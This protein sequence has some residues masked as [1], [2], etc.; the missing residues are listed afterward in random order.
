MRRLSLLLSCAALLVA[1]TGC[2][3]FSQRHPPPTTPATPPPAAAPATSPPL[4]ANLLALAEVKTFIQ[5][6]ALRH[7]FNPDELNRLLGAANVQRKILDAMAAPA[8]AKPWH[9]YRQ[10]FLT[11]TRIQDGARFWNQYA[12]ALEQASMRYGVPAEYLIAI[13]G[14]ET[15]YGRNT[16]GYRVIDALATLGFFHPQ[17]GGYF[18]SELEAFLLLCREESIDPLVPKGSYAGA[19]GFPQFMPS[20][21]RRFAVDL[22]GDAR[23]DIWNNPGDA[24]ASV[25]SYFAA[26]GWQTGA[27]VAFSAQVKGN[28]WRGLLDSDLKPRHPAAEVRQKGVLATAPLAGDTPVKLLQMD[29]FQG[30]GYWLTLENFY[31]ITRYNHSPLYAMAV[32]ELAQAIRQRHQSVFPMTNRQ[33]SRFARRSRP[34]GG[35]QGNTAMTNRQESRF[36]RRSRPQGGVQ[37]R[38]P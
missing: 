22:D 9:V 34:Q 4:T 26:H 38:T 13:I 8:E 28:A 14:V 11:E 27:P 36:A 32:H 31:V 12:S 17:R 30:P 33:E 29:E 1:S 6:M 18:R 20:S 10:I 2:A 7:G 16:G 5:E 24:I 35:V 25:G 37:G 23:R 3:T 19:M 21:F 15:S